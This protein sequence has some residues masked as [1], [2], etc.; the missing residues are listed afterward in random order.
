M[1]PARIWIRS[2]LI[3]EPE[4]DKTNK[5]LFASS[6]GSDQPAHQPR[7]IYDYDTRLLH[8][9]SEDSDQADL[10]PRW[11]HILLCWFVLSCSSSVNTY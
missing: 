2:L 1:H 3:I 5:I 11:A 10:S 6:E 4:H 8:T 7:L 9:D